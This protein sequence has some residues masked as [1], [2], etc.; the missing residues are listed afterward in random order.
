MEYNFRPQWRQWNYPT[1]HQPMCGRCGLVHFG[2]TCYASNSKCY[3]C[4]NFGHYSRVCHTRRKTS[5]TE[6]KIKSKGRQDRNSRR[7]ASYLER[8]QLLRELPFSA[9][10]P[11]VFRDCVADTSVIKEELSLA[12]RK[13]SETQVKC[14]DFENKCKDIASDLAESSK[15]ETVLKNLLT[16]VR[17]QNENLTME[18]NQV[19]KN[20]VDNENLQTKLQNVEKELASQTKFWE[21]YEDRCLEMKADY[22]Q[23]LNDETDKFEKLQKRNQDLES[24]LN[25]L[26]M[27]VKQL[28]SENRTY[29]QSNSRQQCEPPRYRRQNNRGR[30]RYGK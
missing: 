19:Q 23:Q 14:N 2:R 10:R 20:I 4:D 3:K 21:S 5:N 9:V 1:C 29:Q 26:S 27:R 28:E 6:T 25:V 16:T 30:G 8:K 24:D 13:L 18:L 7:I 11:G 15:R 12:K 22:I 17:N